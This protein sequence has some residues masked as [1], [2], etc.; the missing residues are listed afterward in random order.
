[1]VRMP[2]TLKLAA[3]SMLLALVVSVPLGILAALK[4]NSI[5]DSL[6]TALATVGVSLPKFWFGLVLMIAALDMLVLTGLCGC[7]L[8]EKEGK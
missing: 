1:M 4:H 3:F 2:A 6:A 7:F 8:L 5:W